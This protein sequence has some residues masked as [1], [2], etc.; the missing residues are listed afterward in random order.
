MAAVSG[1]YALNDKNSMASELLDM[2]S[3]E[4]YISSIP[5]FP[6]TDYLNKNELGS[7]KKMISGK[8]WT[9]TRK[10]VSRQN[11]IVVNG[12]YAL[13]GVTLGIS[14]VNIRTDACDL[15]LDPD[16]K[17]IR[18]ILRDSIGKTTKS[19]STWIKRLSNDAYPC[20][21]FGLFLLSYTYKRH[22]IVIL[23][24]SLWCT[25]KTG[26][27]ST[28]E[29]LCKS[30][31]ILVWLGEDR[32]AEVKP[33]HTK[34]GHNNFAE[35]QLLVESI[36]HLHQRSTNPKRQCRVAKSTASISTLT[37]R[38]SLSPLRTRSSDQRGS[39]V[40]IDYKQ[41][42]EDG[43][44]EVKERTSDK[45]L[46]KSSGPS[47]SRQDSQRH[48]ARNK[49]SPQTKPTTGSYVPRRNI[50]V[51]VPSNIT[52]K[53]EIAAFHATSRNVKQEPG[54]FMTR[55]KLQKD[56][57]R[58]WRYVHVS[59]RRCNQGGQLDCNSQS[60]NEADDNPCETLPD[61]PSVPDPRL[62]TSTSNESTIGNPKSGNPHSDTVLISPPPIVRHQN[63]PEENLTPTRRQTTR[64]LD[65]LLCTL[66]FDVIPTVPTEHIETTSP[67]QTTSPECDVGNAIAIS[68]EDSSPTVH[69]KKW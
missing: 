28:L 1:N 24:N 4:E 65:E 27:M 3:V 43:V 8:L 13:F 67:D 30:D 55:R 38:K 11:A 44:I 45:Y 53:R 2:I 64:N 29:K 57:D 59:G 22:V 58:D 18:C 31:H 25:F 16:S 42:H 15:L 46:P 5:A 12:L 51:S 50:A 20:D 36:D 7:L 56:K 10:F 68:S 34:C 41:L 49:S 6:S 61:L 52:I 17:D 9:D 48:I 39:K 35:W 47:K 60:E 62:P 33:L 63:L 32:Y 69:F 26:C 54:I 66:N 14:A 37:K 19:Y 23:A 40:H 21:E